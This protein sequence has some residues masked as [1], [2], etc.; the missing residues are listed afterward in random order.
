MLLELVLLHLLL[1]AAAAAG[2]AGAAAGAA[3]AADAAAVLLLLLQLLLPLLLLL[4]LLLLLLLLLLLPPH[5][6][7]R[8]W[9]LA[10]G[11]R[12]ALRDA[13][14]IDTQQGRKL[15]RGILTGRG[16]AS[17]VGQGMNELTTGP[18]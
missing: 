10:R 3:G 13:G 12:L 14:P 7:C 5:S 6:T 8:F 2:A 18:R 4:M 17:C 9:R 16:P 15:G 1:P 11:L